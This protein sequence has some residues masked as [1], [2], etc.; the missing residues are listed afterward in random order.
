[1]TLLHMHFQFT[2]WGEGMTRACGKWLKGVFRPL[3]IVKLLATLL[4]SGNSPLPVHAQ[5]IGPLQI[6]I[7]DRYGNHRIVL[8]HESDDC[9]SPRWSPD[10]THILFTV[11]YEPQSQLYDMEADGKNLTN[12]AEIGV[13][14]GP[15][16]WSPDSK[17]IA[18]VSGQDKQVAELYTIDLDGQHKT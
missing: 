17:Q 7:M 1:M 18:F 8:T 16:A 11:G 3:L 9:M 2:N 4:L 6:F 10:G 12:L 14:S 13:F 5:S 15:P